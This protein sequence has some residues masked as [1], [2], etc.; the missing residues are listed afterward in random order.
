MND[1]K[2]YSLT[3][4]W[5]RTLK[6]LYRDGRSDL[7]T[8]IS[9]IQEDEYKLVKH[10]VRLNDVA[11][12][13]GAHIGAASLAL[14]SRGALVYSVECLP[15]NVSMMANNFIAN[16]YMSRV[17]IYHNSIDA[18]DEVEVVAYHTKP[19]DSTGYIH[20]YIGCT[21]PHKQLGGQEDGDEVKVRT[22]SLAKIFRENSLKR[23]RFLKID[24]EGAEWAA[25]G[26]APAWVLDSIDIISGEVHRITP[27]GEVKHSDLLPLLQDK[28]ADV[29]EEYEPVYSKPGPVTH[30]VYK[31]RRVFGV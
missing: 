2:E 3:T 10:D 31:N 5:G 26:G 8:F 7:N 21:I 29:T 9:C 18:T 24:C 12:D 28:F 15:D 16:R 20:E 14:L 11:I 4:P 30:F 19:S 23:C 22:I 6:C 17:R 27:N 13:I 1:I 25:L